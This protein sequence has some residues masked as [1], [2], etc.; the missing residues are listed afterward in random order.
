GADSPAA[1]AGACFG[2][3]FSRTQLPGRG[4]AAGLAP[5]ESQCLDCLRLAG[6]PGTAAGTGWRDP[7]RPSLYAAR[8]TGGGP[9]AR[10]AEIAAYQQ[11]SGSGSAKG[12]SRRGSR[13]LAAQPGPLS[14]T[15]T[16][17]EGCSGAMAGQ[18]GDGLCTR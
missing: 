15:G 3:V 5:Q 9:T 10:A 8:R 4:A 16:A 11:M 6:R 17:S 12:A 14:A 1:A 2:T 13:A 7:A 18:A